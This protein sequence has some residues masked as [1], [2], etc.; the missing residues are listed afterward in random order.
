M[1]VTI[2]NS[3]DAPGRS[4]RRVA[5]IVRATIQVLLALQIAIGGVLKLAGDPTMIDL[6]TDIGW[7]QWLRLFVGVCEVAGAIAL[8][9]PRL[10]ALAAVALTALLAG[11]VITNVAIGANPAVPAVF[12]L[13]AAGLAISLRHRL[14]RLTRNH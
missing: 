12:G 7:G 3:A 8:L 11:A 10:A 6:F 4:P 1:N 13:I 14:P 5:T 9:I 2:D